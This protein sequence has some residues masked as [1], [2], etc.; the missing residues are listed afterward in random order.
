MLKPLT[1]SA[2]GGILYTRSK[3][4]D[5]HISGGEHIKNQ[6]GAFS[7]SNTKGRDMTTKQFL[8]FF[9]SGNFEGTSSNGQT[10]ADKA[11]AM[12]VSIEKRNEKA[13]QREKVVKRVDNTEAKETIRAYLACYSESVTGK[14]IAEHTEMTIQKATAVI[15]QL[16]ADGEVERIKLSR[17]K[18]LEYKLK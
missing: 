12:L 2:F 14:D 11:T 6:I 1:F 8:E 18:P 10:M 9:L 15:R 16:V 7:M 4:I 3:E 13:K 17:N 5:L